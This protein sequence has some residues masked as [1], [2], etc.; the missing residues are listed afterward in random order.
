MPII[1]TAVNVPNLLIFSFILRYQHDHHCRPLRR[2]LIRAHEALRFIH[3]A[4]YIGYWSGPWLL[5]TTWLFR[6]FRQTA[7]F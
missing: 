4:K 5:S 3:T 1:Q 7:V 6:L 2:A